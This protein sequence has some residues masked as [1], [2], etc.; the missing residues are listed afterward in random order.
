MLKTSEILKN[1]NLYGQDG[2]KLSTDTDIFLEDLSKTKRHELKT[3]YNLEAVFEFQK[4]PLLLFFNN[5]SQSVESELHKW[6]WNYNKSVAIVIIRDST[7]DIYNGFSFNQDTKLLDLLEN[8]F[9]SNDDRFS[10]TNIL[11][12][13]TWLAYK[14]KIS[15]KHRY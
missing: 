13:T 5:P 2:C 3:K 14:D 1:M 6:I 9:N 7:I 11:T 8:N 4:Q 10:F 12:G 15:Q